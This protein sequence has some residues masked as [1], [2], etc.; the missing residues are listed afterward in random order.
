VSQNRELIIDDIPRSTARSVMPVPRNPTE[1][2]VT[3]LEV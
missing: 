3:N 1:P 2:A